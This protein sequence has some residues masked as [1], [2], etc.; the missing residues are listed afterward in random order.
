MDEKNHFVCGIK[1]AK[2]PILGITDLYTKLCKVSV[3]A[4]QTDYIKVNLVNEKEEIVSEEI[5]ESETLNEEQ[6]LHE[7]KC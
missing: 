1:V 5:E 4:I 2:D 3:W 6:E 7:L